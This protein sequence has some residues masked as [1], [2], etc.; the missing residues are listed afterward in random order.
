MAA[1]TGPRWCAWSWAGP[2]ACTA[3]PDSRPRA[4]LHCMRPPCMRSTVAP[5]VPSSS[6]V[7]GLG[8]G[9]SLRCTL[10]GSGCMRR[11]SLVLHAAALHAQHCC[12]H[13]A[14]LE[15]CAQL[16]VGHEATWAQ[17]A[18]ETCQAGH[19]I[20]RRRAGVKV[21]CCRALGLHTA[22][23][24]GLSSSSRSSSATSA[25]AETF[26]ELVPAPPAQNTGC[27]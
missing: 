23:E 10:A 20:P 11:C 9:V 13:G 22:A 15:H 18:S 17:D 14:R 19:Q 6:T 7:P 24:S 8:E 12:P 3:G 16:G 21:H 4:H 26:F 25:S 1:I 2:Q 5:A 27:L